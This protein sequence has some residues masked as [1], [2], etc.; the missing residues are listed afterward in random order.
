[1]SGLKPVGSHML[2]LILEYSKLAAAL[3]T[4]LHHMSVSGVSIPDNHGMLCYSQVPMSPHLLFLWSSFLFC[5][6]DELFAVLDESERL[7]GEIDELT[8]LKQK[9]VSY[10]AYM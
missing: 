5:L 2:K 8:K 4:T 1:M 10:R 9:K 7:L 3:D 6:L